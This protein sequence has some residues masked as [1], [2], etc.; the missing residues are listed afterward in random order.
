MIDCMKKVYIYG[1]DNYPPGVKVMVT[2]TEGL[3]WTISD[4]KDVSQ[5]AGVA[6]GLRLLDIQGREEMECILEW[7]DVGENALQNIEKLHLGF[8]PKLQKLFEGD[9]VQTK[10]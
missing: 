1:G 2:H 4:V 5:L 7:S 3:E 6:N 9:V 8:L 10:K